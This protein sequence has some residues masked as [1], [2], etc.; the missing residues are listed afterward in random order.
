MCNRGII[1]QIY[2]KLC[3]ERYDRGKDGRAIMAEIKNDK[4]PL[5]SIKLYKNALIYLNMLY[6]I[7]RERN[8]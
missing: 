3:G 2:T 4:I 1:H 5:K 8:G 6:S 7:N